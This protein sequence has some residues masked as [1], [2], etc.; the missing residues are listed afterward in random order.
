MARME[1]LKVAFFFEE[2]RGGWGFGQVLVVFHERMVI[3][4][5]DLANGTFD[6]RVKQ[7]YLVKYRVQIRSF[8]R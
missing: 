1:V 4:G 6:F 3:F 7:R 5:W 2:A 8:R